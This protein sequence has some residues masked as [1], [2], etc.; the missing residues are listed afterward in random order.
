MD[1]QREEQ[2]TGGDADA[3]RRAV[4]MGGPATKPLPEVQI[5]VDGDTISLA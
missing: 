2:P 1:D 5:R 4:I 3:C